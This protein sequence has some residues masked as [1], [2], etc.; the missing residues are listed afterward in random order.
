MVL[1]SFL[2]IPNSTATPLVV[3]DVPGPISY[4]GL[5]EGTGSTAVDAFNNNDGTIVGAQ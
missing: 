2:S 1:M 5:S 3:A 4:W